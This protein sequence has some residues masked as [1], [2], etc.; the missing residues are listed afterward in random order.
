M[1]EVAD[2]PEQEARPINLE[3]LAP[4]Q[5]AES[6]R[7]FAAAR[8]SSPEA[9]TAV[10][11]RD[12]I[13]LD[14]I[15]PQAEARYN[16]ILEPESLRERQ[17]YWETRNIE[18]D[19]ALVQWKSRFTSLVSQVTSD[20][21]TT[22][23]KSILPEGNQELRE[24]NLA[25]ITQDDAMTLFHEYSDNKSDIDKFMRRALTDPT[26]IDA[27]K[28]MLP[29]LKW[30]A[31]GFFGKDTAAKIENQ[32]LLEAEVK[33][34]PVDTSRFFEETIRSHE[35]PRQPEAAV[36]PTD[37]DDDILH[38]APYEQRLD[39][40]PIRPQRPEG[41]DDEEKEVE[42]PTAHSETETTPAKDEAESSTAQDQPQDQTESQSSQAPESSEADSQAQTQN[43]PDT[44]ASVA[45][46]AK[47][48]PQ[49]DA[50]DELS[51]PKSLQ[52]VD[53]RITEQAT[54]EPDFNLIEEINKELSLKIR[55]MN[56]SHVYIAASPKALMNYIISSLAGGMKVEI[57]EMNVTPDDK[58][59]INEVKISEKGGVVT[60]KNVSV[61]NDPNNPGRILANA[62]SIDKNLLARTFA[63]DVESKISNVND[64]A[65]DK[66]KTQMAPGNLSWQPKNLSILEGNIIV[67]FEKEKAAL[68]NPA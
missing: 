16:L 13:S 22:A 2:R 29:H 45:T 5:R 25:D 49:G 30:I 19:E 7:Y 11:T 34:N 27:L 21:R 42:E 64:A 67:G 18:F 60:L 26:D 55:F 31:T 36:G 56:K 33:F 3:N 65:L 37:D 32:L 1:V 47:N 38:S 15:N 61:L 9:A 6:I 52:D 8:A 4:E 14:E 24:K 23:I 12:E 39:P 10:L 58:V 17:D 41:N 54:N 62:G 48:E 35:E 28:E 43:P 40:A 46:E 59:S 20:T 57:G 63:G 66:L 50:T 68:P 44:N 51:I 53:I